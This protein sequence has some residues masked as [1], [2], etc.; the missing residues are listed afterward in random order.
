[1]SHTNRFC[2]RIYRQLLLSLRQRLVEQ[3]EKVLND[4]RKLDTLSRVLDPTPK[5]RQQL[6]KVVERATSQQALTDVQR[7]LCEYRRILSIS[8]LA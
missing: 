3:H 7:L 4:Q 8:Y 1:M 2:R 6:N 5:Q